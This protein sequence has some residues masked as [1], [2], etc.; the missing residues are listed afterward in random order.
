MNSDEAQALADVHAL[1]DAHA[2]ALA[3]AHDSLLATHAQA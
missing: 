1:A 2:H 3:H